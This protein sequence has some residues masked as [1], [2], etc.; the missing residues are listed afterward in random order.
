MRLDLEL[1]SFGEPDVCVGLTI[2][3]LDFGFGT[4]D[5]MS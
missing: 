4:E 1:S 2:F 3:D 5:L